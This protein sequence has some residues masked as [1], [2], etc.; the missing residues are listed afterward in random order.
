MPVRIEEANLAT[1]MDFAFNHFVKPLDKRDLLDYR[2]RKIDPESKDIETAW[3][4]DNP[5]TGVIYLKKHPNAKTAWV[6]VKFEQREETRSIRNVPQQHKTIKTVN[7]FRDFF[8]V[9]PNQNFIE[10]DTQVL[11]QWQK[12]ERVTRPRR[13]FDE[14]TPNFYMY[15]N[16]L[17]TN[18]N[19]LIQ[20]LY[21]INDYIDTTGSESDLFNIPYYLTDIK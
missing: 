18:L 7:E 4:R 19:T 17:K 11:V 9:T 2:P 10:G 15:T 8:G 12:E 14:T 6:L 1:A 13:D 21:R 16:H 20:R 5:T 3:Q